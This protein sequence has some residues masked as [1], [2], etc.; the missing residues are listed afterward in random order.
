M[1]ANLINWELIGCRLFASE[2]SGSHVHAFST[3]CVIRYSLSGGQ[4]LHYSR[5]GG[6]SSTIFDVGWM[7]AYRFFMYILSA[8]IYYKERVQ[9]LTSRTAPCVVLLYIINYACLADL[10]PF[11][12]EYAGLITETANIF[13]P[14]NFNTEV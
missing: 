7:P 11:D 12:H 5:T 8:M 13:P 9:W 14:F 4:F 2:P 10:F 6:V 1:G 3:A